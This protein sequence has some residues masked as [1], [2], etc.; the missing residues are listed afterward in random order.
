M[1][2]TMRTA[3]LTLRCLEPDD[4]RVVHAMHSG[5]GHTVGDGP[6]AD[7]AATESWLARR[8]A[9]YR[10][11]GLA[12]YGLW[13]TDRQFV[14]TCGVFTGERCGDEP[15]IGYEIDIPRRGQGFAKEAA[16]AV[17]EE[18]HGAGHQHVWATIR[19]SNQASVHIV[20]SIGFELVRAQSDAKGALNYYVSTTPRHTNP[21]D[22]QR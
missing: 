20:N 22:T 18:A 14:G 1:R 11:Q 5:E 4:L 17:T 21:S 13:D 2:K 19:P 15:E 9:R 6:I 12:W 10:D 3:R 8:Q 16:R 7:V